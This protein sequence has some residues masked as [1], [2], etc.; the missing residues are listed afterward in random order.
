[1]PRSTDCGRVGEE[2]T[3]V[4]LVHVPNTSSMN[5]IFRLSPVALV[6]LSLGLTMLVNS[7]AI[8]PVRPAISMAEVVAAATGELA[9]A[10]QQVLAVG[11][12]VECD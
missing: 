5:R 12:T 6:R 7:A 10:W 1:M 2:P 3:F 4:E 11:S 9:A 8:G